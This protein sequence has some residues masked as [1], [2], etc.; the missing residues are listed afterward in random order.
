MWY[1]F[2]EAAEIDKEVL[3]NFAKQCSPEDCIMEVLDYWLRK[4]IKQPTWTDVAK[5]LKIIHLSQLALQ[6]ENVYITGTNDTIY[7]LFYTY[8]YE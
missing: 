4:C 5:I 1:K 7:L 2:G 3:D 6:I 8:Q